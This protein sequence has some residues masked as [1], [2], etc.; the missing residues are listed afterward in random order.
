MDEKKEIQEAAESENTESAA[1]K[2]LND[3]SFLV[4]TIIEYYQAKAG[5]K[6]E[7]DDGEGWKEGTVHEPPAILPK[8]IDEIVEKA[9]LKQLRKFV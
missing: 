6:G 9:F 4:S 7:L 5:F 8:R 3:F 1:S 2:E